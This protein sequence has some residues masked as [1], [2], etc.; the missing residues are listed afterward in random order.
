MLGVFVGGDC[1]KWTCNSYRGYRCAKAVA[2]NIDEYLGLSPPDKC[3]VEIPE[4]SLEIS[5][6]GRVELKKEKLVKEFSILKVLKIA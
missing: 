4:A 1:A 2:A 3:D 5:P 6:C